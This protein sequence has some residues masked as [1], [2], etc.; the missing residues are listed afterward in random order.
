MSTLIGV[1]EEKVEFTKESLTETEVLNETQLPENK[2][3]L[4]KDFI[5]IFTTALAI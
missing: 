1:F 3:S 4:K 5:W 2:S